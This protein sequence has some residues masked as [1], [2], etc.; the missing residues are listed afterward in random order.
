MHSREAL[1]LFP[2]ALGDMVCLEPAVA[3]LAARGRVLTI[4]ARGA[5]REVT[6]FFPARPQAVSLDAP[7]VARLFAPIM[8]GDPPDIPAPLRAAG[9][10]V[11]FTGRGHPAAEARLA[12]AGASAHPFPV[13]AGTTGH[14]ADIF[15]AAVSDGH[16]SG[17]GVP[18]LMPVAKIA[19]EPGLLVVHPGSGGSAK[20]APASIWLGL[21]DDWRRVARGSVEVLLGPAEP[22]EDDRW[23][24]VGASVVRPEDTSALVGRIARA[25]VFVGNDAGPSHVA[26][27]LGVRTIV[28]YTVTQPAAF[29]PRGFVAAVQGAHEDPERALAT[30]SRLA[31]TAHGCGLNGATWLA[32]VS[33][34]RGDFSRD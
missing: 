13:R 2:G 26:A 15:L 27:A 21:I 23:R 19:V 9:L 29:G 20:R 6:S 16:A 1:I 31:L 22:Q 25:S 7:W 24:A 12:A 11:S 3:W 4:A 34:Q 5:A 32:A 33:E 14:A 28:F 17:P 10:V 18:R 8:V 30:A